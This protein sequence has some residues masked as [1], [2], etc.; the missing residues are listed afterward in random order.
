MFGLTR[1]ARVVCPSDRALRP[2]NVLVCRRGGHYIV[3]QSRP[4]T[5]EI[6]A[7]KLSGESAKREIPDTAAPTGSTASRGLF[8][9][10][11]ET[12]QYFNHPKTTNTYKHKIRATLT[13]VVPT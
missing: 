13:L 11:G 5:S 1:A 12:S 7:K 10:L 8:A 2:P 3:R 6:C 4:V 9:T